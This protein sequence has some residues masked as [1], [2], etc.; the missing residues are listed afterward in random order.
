[1]EQNARNIIR[2]LSQRSDS[3]IRQRLRAAC[4]VH[5]F[6]RVHNMGQ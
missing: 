2:N 3:R 6:G 5:E 1:M 4:V